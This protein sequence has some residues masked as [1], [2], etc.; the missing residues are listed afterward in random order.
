MTRVPNKL[1]VSPGTGG[2]DDTYDSG[3]VT[4]P[5]LTY[6]SPKVFIH[7]RGGI[8][9]NIRFLL[10][11]VTNEIS[12]QWLTTD[13]VLE[14][15]V[16]VTPPHWTTVEY[17]PNAISWLL[18]AGQTLTARRRYSYNY[19][20]IDPARWNMRCIASNFRGN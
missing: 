14:L 17:T 5:T 1:L 8:P 2:I 4:L 7:N 20:F 18:Y 11:C 9:G 6:D 10:K 16:G 13:P 15:P 19:F 3:W 12:D